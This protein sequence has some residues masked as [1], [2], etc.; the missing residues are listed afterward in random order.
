LF[1]PSEVVEEV[2]A[3]NDIVDVVSSYVQLKRKS[4]SG[5]FGLCPFHRE[6]TPSFSV[7]ADRQMYHCFGCGAGGNV[8]GFI[9]QIE[10]HDF[11]DAL[12]LLADRAHITLPESNAID[13]AEYAR[14]AKEKELILEI[15]KAA[16]RFYYDALKTFEG[17]AASRYLDSRRVSPKTRVRFGLGYSPTERTSLFNYLKGKGYEESI[18]Q[19]AGLAM[20]DKN[21]GLRDRFYGR[22]MF[23]IIEAMGGI[24][25]FGG[26]ILAEGEP[27]YLNSP[28]TPA[29]DKSRNLYGIQFARKAKNR[30]IILVEGYMD[31]IALHQAGFENAVAALGTA[32]NSNH[33]KLLRKYCEDAVL[34][35]D[36]DEAGTKAALRA[37]PV[38]RDSAMPVKVLQVTGA[39]DPDEYIQ[40][41]G[42]EA[43]AELLTAAD[44]D[45]R[46]RV[47]QL[48]KGFDLSKTDEKVKFTSEAAK[49]V[50]SLQSPVER[51]AYGKEI[52]EIAGLSAEAVGREAD[53]E[54]L[55]EAQ[56][57][58]ARVGAA[59]GRPLSSGRPTAGEP[60]PA[61]RRPYSGEPLPGRGVVSGEFGFAP[62]G[63]PMPERGLEEAKRRLLY[64][65]AADREV[66]AAIRPHLEPRELGDAAY[67]RLLGL[68]YDAY[69]HGK[70]PVPAGLISF[71]ETTE[72]QKRISGVFSVNGEYES[73]GAL[74][75]AVND[76][77]RVVK[78]SYI[79]SLMRASDLKSLKNLVEIKRN[80]E[81]LYITISD[82]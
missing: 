57:E 39:K 21:G 15:N 33:V 29:F 10:N 48:L 76:M 37:I 17:G 20:P 11:P 24:V 18:I 55:K 47:N 73:G 6:K 30:T 13:A 28:D 9:M 7:N 45:V 42:P 68:I 1:Y 64:W 19:K 67:E 16:A 43:F 56:K 59:S 60:W 32:F 34:L 77:L 12:K 27:K 58:A 69:T 4:G 75:K 72:E 5:Y 74:E 52:A 66:Y 25:G 35:F 70:T 44:T 3:A 50:A 46:F 23:P 22:L 14:R 80:V 41:F 81:N 40:K 53:R 31:V 79:E 36:S 54:T 63:S 65:I 78:S 61:S 2:R 49:I 26:R 51:D 38:F 82:G 8:I 62:R 71:F